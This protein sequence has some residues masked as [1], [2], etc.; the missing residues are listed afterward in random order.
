MSRWLAALLLVLAGAAHAATL[1]RGN[2]GEPASLDPHF[3]SGTWEANIVGDLMTGL[4]TLDATARPIPGMADRWTVSPDG[5]TWTFHLR[6]AVWSDGVPVTAEDF[7]FAFRRLLDPKTAARNGANLWVIQNAKAISAGRLPPSALGVAAPKPD[8]LILHLAHPAAYLPELLT[9]ESAFPLPR[10]VVAKNGA[11]WARPGVYVGNGAYLL[12]EWVPGDHI[13]L[14]RNPKFYDARTVR[15]DTVKYY[16]TTDT[17]AAVKRYRAGELDTQNP[18]PTQDLAWL[19]THLPGEVKLTSSLAIAYIAIN[20]NDP[21]LK[22]RRVRRALNLIYNRE[23]LVDK[24]LK[25][26][27][28]PAYSIVPPGTANYPGGGVMDFR[29]KPFPARLAE[30]QHLM[31]EA[32]YG[33]FNRLRL[34]YATYA[35]PDA[36]RLAAIFQAMVKPIYVDI[37]VEISDL[38]TVMQNL[39]QHRFQLSGA[40]WLA[41]FNDASN[42]LDILRGGSDH[43]YAG[44]R[45]A[46]FDAAMDA[47]ENEPDVKKRAAL[48]LQAER[49]ALADY[50]WIPVRFL[51]QSDLVKPVVK[52]WQPNPRDIHPSRW[53]W[54]AR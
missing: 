22:D 52:G 6:K 49:L 54:L 15:I 18:L 51:V 24:V 11:G 39:R 45:N 7:A 26:G 4:T 48:L 31:Q 2:G 21:A 25:L 27:E 5:K 8:T 10:H 17:A 35:S 32:G 43:N 50:P 3:I 40:S 28:K 47:A 41:D 19:R 46:K 30:A 38:P 14:I 44:Y 1:N 9:H 36:R 20:Q 53:M 16:P 29:D 12:K 13:T 23:A 37:S 33:P 34:A 42:F